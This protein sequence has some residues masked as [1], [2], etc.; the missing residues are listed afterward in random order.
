LFILIFN[1]R[2]ILLNAV[3]DSLSE[4]GFNRVNADF[5]HLIFFF[6]RFLI[7]SRLTGLLNDKRKVSFLCALSVFAVQK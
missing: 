4:G 3:F 7:P 2:F 6:C 5:V 1:R